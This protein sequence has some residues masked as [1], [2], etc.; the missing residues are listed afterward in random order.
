[1]LFYVAGS[2][3]DTNTFWTLVVSTWNNYQGLKFSH[4]RFSFFYLA[5]YYLVFLQIAED[6]SHCEFLLRLPGYCPSMQLWTWI[7]CPFLFSC[8]S[9]ALQYST[10]LDSGNLFVLLL[11]NNCWFC[12]ACIPRCY[13][14]TSC[15]KEVA[16]IPCRGVVYA[17]I[18][19]F[20][21]HY[22]G[23]ICQVYYHFAI[24]VR[25]ELGIGEDVKLVLFNFG[26]QV[27]HL[28]YVPIYTIYTN[29]N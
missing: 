18:I 6:Y 28:F 1:M 12:S 26:G 16:Q 27:R 5:N 15:C 13:W 20:H 22:N 4:G 29:W 10:Y 25:S 21:W 11:N 8:S 17:C 9:C 3:P 2:A 7:M 14:C 23:S 19:Y 24:Q